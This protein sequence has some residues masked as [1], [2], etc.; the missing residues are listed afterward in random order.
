MYTA[1]D[2]TGR[3]CR[4]FE[5]PEGIPDHDEMVRCNTLDGETVVNGNFLEGYCLGVGGLPTPIPAPP[6]PYH[7]WDWDTK[8][9]TGPHLDQAR[10]EV[11]ERIKAERARRW[12]AGFAHAGHWWHSDA[13][14]RLQYLTNKDLARDQLDEGDTR[15]APLRNLATGEQVAWK[16]MS[17]TVPLTAGLA[18]DVAK[19]AKVHEAQVFAAA[20]QHRAAVMTSDDPYAYDYLPGWPENF[21]R[22]GEP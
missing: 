13:D 20:E 22:G 19:A 8:S 21:K 16:A 7:Q 3:P 15:D 1:F 2:S 9:Y 14:S 18:L 17:G 5:L 12:A 11:W 10:E 6:S 4:I